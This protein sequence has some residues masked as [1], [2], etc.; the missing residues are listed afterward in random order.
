MQCLDQAD[1]SVDD[2]ADAMCMSSS[3]LFRKL[4]AIIGKNPNEYLRIK[5][6]K[7]AAELLQQGR[8]GVAD[9]SLMVGFSSS[10]YFS[11]CFKKQFGI[12]PSEFL[13]RG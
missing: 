13:D 10:T 2:M 12:S 5:R 6:L 7:R 11:S 9:I 4:K 8:Y 3:S 1:L